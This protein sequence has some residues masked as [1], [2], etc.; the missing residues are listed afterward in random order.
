MT[1]TPYT[2]QADDRRYSGE[3]ADITYSLKRCIHAE[4]CIHRLSAVFDPKKRPWIQADGASA[5]DLVAMVTHCP[6]GALHVERKDGG[7]PEAPPAENTITLWKDGPL[8]LEGDLSLYGAQVAIDHET[9]LTLCRCGASNN[10]PFCDNAHL[11]TGFTASDPLPAVAT[12]PVSDPPAM[13]SGKLS[14]T[15]QAN[16]SLAVTGVFTMRAPD[17]SMLSYGDQAWLC[18]CG[19]SNNKP[20]CDGTHRTVGFTAE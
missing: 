11:K 6:S 15:A 10:K 9:R 16:G 3:Q 18:R 17:G 20:F 7:V 2:G 8:Q 19:Q 1:D 5:D 14:V 13:S 4:E 12:T